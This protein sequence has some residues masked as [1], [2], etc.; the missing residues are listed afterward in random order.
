LKIF[1]E[2]KGTNIEQ[3]ITQKA[4]KQNDRDYIFQTQISCIYSL[5]WKKG[6]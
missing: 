2:Y 1:V 4:H 6:L 3:K 5:F